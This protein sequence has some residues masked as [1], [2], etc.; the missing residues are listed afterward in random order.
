[1]RDVGTQLPEVKQAQQPLPA[2]V[3]APLQ[4]ETNIASL[5]GRRE[6]ALRQT[7]E[8]IEDALEEVGTGIDVDDIMNRYED[9]AA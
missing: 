6:R 7:R 8:Q 3:Q 1:M 5:E 2:E 4:P 9:L